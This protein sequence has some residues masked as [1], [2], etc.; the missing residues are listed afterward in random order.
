[1]ADEITPEQ[2]EQVRVAAQA[3]NPEMAEKVIRQRSRGILTFEEY[4]VK[5]AEVAGWV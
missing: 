4:V 2:V 3:R 1:M 5:L